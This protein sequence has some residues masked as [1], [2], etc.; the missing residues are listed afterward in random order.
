MSQRT[1]FFHL[2]RTPCESGV[3]HR[4]RGGFGCAAHHRAVGLASTRCVS[5]AS[6]VVGYKV[7]ET[8][9]DSSALNPGFSWVTLKVYKRETVLG[10]IS[11]CERVARRR[12]ISPAVIR[13]VT[14][15]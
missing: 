10:T 8:L 1:S 7:S 4:V 11:R 12:L 15:Y 2:R 14:H 13:F 6:L 3:T 5:P 9:S